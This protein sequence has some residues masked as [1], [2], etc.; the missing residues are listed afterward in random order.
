MPSDLPKLFTA[1]MPRVKISDQELEWIF[2]VKPR[3]LLLLETGDFIL[4]ETGDRIF[5]EDADTKSQVMRTANAPPTHTSDMPTIST[6]N[7]PRTRT[8]G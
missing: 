6:V 5:T 8:G 3:G 1:A 4:Q 7:T 2:A